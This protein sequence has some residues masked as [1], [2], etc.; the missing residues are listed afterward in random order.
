MK[1]RARRMRALFGIGLVLTLS[2]YGLANP[3]HPVIPNPVITFLGAEY[4]TVS[5]S[6][7]TRYYFEVFNR[8]DYPPDMFAA[9]PKLPPCGANTNASRT[10]IDIF[11][12]SGKRLYGFCAIGKPDDLNKLWFGLPSDVVPPSWIYIEFTDRQTNTKYK[13]NLAET[14]L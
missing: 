10:W 14:V 8:E 5:G 6:Q 9:S 11:D 13:S 2:T 4:L 7:Q 12:Q 3:A 1:N